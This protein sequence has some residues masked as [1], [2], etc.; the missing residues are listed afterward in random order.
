MFPKIIITNNL[1]LEQF[2][3]YSRIFFVKSF[4]LLVSHINRLIR[5]EISGL[6]SIR[7]Y[8]SRIKSSKKQIICGCARR[9]L[10]TYPL[11]PNLCKVRGVFLYERYLNKIHFLVQKGS[12]SIPTLVFLRSAICQ[13]SLTPPT[14]SKFIRTF[15]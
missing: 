11:S 8:Y 2:K 6:I 1:S 4:N 12:I 7:I 5:F 15:L 13:F 9:L 10:N 3:K 14:Y